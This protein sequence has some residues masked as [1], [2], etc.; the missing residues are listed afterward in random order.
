MPE[1][2]AV[3]ERLVRQHA[4]AAQQQ[5]VGEVAADTAQQSAGN[6]ENRGPVQPAAQFLGELCIGHGDRRGGID[7][8][9]QF[10]PCDHM[11]DQ[12]DEV[13]ALDPRHPLPARTER[14][15]EA[16][17]ERRQHPRDEAAIGADHEADPQTDHTH[18]MRFR[19]TR[20]VLPG[21][22][23]FVAEAGVR[24]G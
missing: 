11:R 24:F 14:S 18:A 1:H 17:F 5:F 3:A 9:C 20:R 23:E 22:A 10:G 19:R 8:P 12:A 13:V 7:R 6:P 21:V 4:L 16:E 2:E 15:A